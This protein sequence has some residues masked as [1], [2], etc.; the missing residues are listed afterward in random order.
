VIPAGG[1]ILRQW[2]AR[3]LDIVYP[4]GC[5]VCRA[6]VA[7]HG[8]LCVTCWRQIRFIEQPCC[9][10]LGVPFERDLGQGNLISPEAVANPPAFR[11][12]RAVARYDSDGARALAYRLKYRDRMD[13]AEPMGRWM[14]R[15]GTGLLSDA[16]LIIPVPLHRRRLF[17]RRFNQAAALARVVSRESGVPLDA[18]SLLRI[19]PTATQVGFSRSQRIANLSGAFQVDDA[20]ASQLR[21]KNILLVDDVLTTGATANAATRALLKSG[22]NHVDLLVFARAVAGS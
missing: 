20:C 13:L 8:G 11:R 6:A 19:K 15:A 14:A 10:R 3:L 1:A 21:G 18:M 17:A 12:A 4:P 7:N 5:L 22:A 16:D 9:D 2:G